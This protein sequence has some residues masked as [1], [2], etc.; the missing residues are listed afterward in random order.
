[1]KSNYT[2]AFRIC[3]TGMSFLCIMFFAYLCDRNSKIQKF[4]MDLH[5]RNYLSLER[6][7]KKGFDPDI[8]LVKYL[9]R[10]AFVIVKYKLFGLLNPEDWPGD[11]GP[12]EQ[13]YTGLGYAV[14]NNDVR[15]AKLFLDYKASLKPKNISNNILNSPC[16]TVFIDTKMLTLL[17]LYGADLNS[18]EVCKAMLEMAKYTKDQKATNFLIKLG[19][20]K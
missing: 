18:S 3:L 19:L 7:L 4:E 5:S 9:S 17:N 11:L 14:E 10:D 15:L 20:K 6:T 16:K 2:L 8:I 12:F 1:M 13:G